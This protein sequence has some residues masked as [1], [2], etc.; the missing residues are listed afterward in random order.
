MARMDRSSAPPSLEDDA[1]VEL[2]AEL[3]V[4]S[5]AGQTTA[6]EIRTLFSLSRELF[7]VA[8]FDGHFQLVSP[9]W[10][11]TLGHSH[12]ELCA[13]PYIDFVHPADR[14]MTREVVARLVQSGRLIAFQNRYRQRSGG[15]RTLSWR[16]TVN[17][18]KQRI[19]A[20]ALDVS[21]DITA[22][23]SAS[24][25]SAILE[26]A[27]E[28]IIVQSAEGVI[29]SWNPAAER[30]CGWSAAEVIGKPMGVVTQSTASAAAA[31]EEQL[32]RSESSERMDAVLVHKDGR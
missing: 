23:E 9:S 4:L 14:P 18:E 27:G 1:L 2:A 8:G 10:T 5:G 19:Y 13:V 28:A 25:L 30:L 20:V 32:N 29:T 6:A 16:A 15:Y 7:L 17:V 31:V 26:M 11:A 24:T 12:A 21:D 22:R 3:G